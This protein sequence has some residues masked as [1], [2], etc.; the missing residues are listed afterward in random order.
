MQFLT[1][2]GLD[3]LRFLLEM[4]VLPCQIAGMPYKEDCGKF[5]LLC[6]IEAE[7]ERPGMGLSG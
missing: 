1:A 4:F 7:V 6:E 2:N 5:E 3:R